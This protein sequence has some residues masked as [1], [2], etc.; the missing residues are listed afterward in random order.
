MILKIIQSFVGNH[1][2]RNS[3]IAWFFILLAICVAYLPITQ[4][5][6][7]IPTSKAIFSG[8]DHQTAMRLSE[9]VFTLQISEM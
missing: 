3:T 9:A 1:I 7:P 5:A 6:F 4:Q 8:K 2:K